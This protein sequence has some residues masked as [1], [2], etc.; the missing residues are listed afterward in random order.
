[1]TLKNQ[2]F[3]I[4]I[5]NWIDYLIIKTASTKRLPFYTPNIKIAHSCNGYDLI[6]R[7]HLFNENKYQY[8]LPNIQ[9]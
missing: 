6:S 3:N 2:F 7:I 9:L 4:L 5:F 8:F 1:M